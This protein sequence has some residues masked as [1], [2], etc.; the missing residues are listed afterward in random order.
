MYTGSIEHSRII[1]AFTRNVPECYVRD[2]RANGSFI[3]ICR[4]YRDVYDK[5]KD[6]ASLSRAVPAETL[7][8]LPRG[9][10]QAADRMAGARLVRPGW[11]RAMLTA[12][13]VLTDNQRH[14]I[15]KAL[16]LQVFA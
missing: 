1:E 13:V 3:A 12:A 4:G 11:R 5:D 16:G 9:N 6:T 7:C 15:Q 10:V 2:Y 14:R 8:M